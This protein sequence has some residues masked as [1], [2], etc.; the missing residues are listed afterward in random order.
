MRQ[1]DISNEMTT[2]NQSP[3]VMKLKKGKI[4][5]PL[6]VIIYPY[7]QPLTYP[8]CFKKKGDKDIHLALLL[9]L[10]ISVF[11]SIKQS[12]KQFDGSIFRPILLATGVHV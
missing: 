2:T 3:Q 10:Y 5:S 11:T 12:D 4:N 9:L 8:Q 1:N 7:V 6:L